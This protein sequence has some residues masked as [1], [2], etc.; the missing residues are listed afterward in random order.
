VAAVPNGGEQGPATGYREVFLKPGGETAQ[1]VDSRDYGIIGRSDVVFPVLHGPYGEDGTVQGLLQLY[2]IPFVGAGVTGSAIGMDKEVMKRLLHDGGIPIPLFHVYRNSDRALKDFKEVSSV[3]GLPLFI[4]PANLGSSVGIS[5]VNDQEDFKRAVR[6]AFRHDQK[7]IVEE[8]I[9]GREIECSVLGNEQP[10]AS[11]PGEIISHHKFYSYD[12]KYVDDRGADLV[13]PAELEKDTV[14]KI[15][16]L[17]VMTFRLTC[18]EGLARV[19]FF[20]RKN[21]DILVNEINTMPGFTNISMY[22]KLWEAS[23]IPQRQ[24]IDRLVELAFE[25]HDR[26]KGL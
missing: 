14:R 5:M 2:D 23:G 12:A 15:Q 25:R 24:L 8:C 1:V 11:M 17:A 18:C 4:K 21:G 10:I 7:I 9:E 19:D 3:L 20:I 6:E 16:D 22:P 13:I 26:E